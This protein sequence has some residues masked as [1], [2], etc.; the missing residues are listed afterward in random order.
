M[1]FSSIQKFFHSKGWLK[2]GDAIVLFPKDVLF[3]VLQ[4]LGLDLLGD[5]LLDFLVFF[6]GNLFSHLSVGWVATENESVETSNT[7][8]DACHDKTKQSSKGVGDGSKNHI[9]QKSPYRVEQE[10]KVDGNGDTEEFELGFE[11]ADQQ[12][13]AN[14]VNCKDKA[15]KRW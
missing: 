2:I 11:T 15:R 10:A 5:P 12:T 13:T 14:G 8:H 7:R 1:T 3:R 9:K 6:F 4:C